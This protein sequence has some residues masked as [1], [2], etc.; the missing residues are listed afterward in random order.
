MVW[1]GEM[2]QGTVQRRHVE[3]GWGGCSGVMGR[4]DSYFEKSGWWV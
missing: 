1:E 3:L 4:P 2:K